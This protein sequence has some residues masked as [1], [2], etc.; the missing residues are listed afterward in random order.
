M[1]RMAIIR[2][3]ICTYMSIGVVLASC[4]SEDEDGGKCEGVAAECRQFGP[5]ARACLLQNGCEMTS[6]CVGVR[7][8][9]HQIVDRDSCHREQCVW[10]AG[11]SVGDP[12]YPSTCRPPSEVVICPEIASSDVCDSKEECEWSEWKQVC[13][14]ARYINSGDCTNTI[15]ESRCVASPSCRWV[16]DRCADSTYDPRITCAERKVEARY[17]YWEEWCPQAIGC[18]VGETCSGSPTECYAMVTEVSCVSQ[19]GCSWQTR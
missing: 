11:S 19:A 15:E 14:V 16:N 5:D 13:D 2:W 10:E 12:S 8:S 6:E 17:S 1:D 3:G 7:I 9:C 18:Y 4:G